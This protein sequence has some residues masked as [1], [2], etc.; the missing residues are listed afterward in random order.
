MYAV[1]AQTFGSLRMHK[2]LVFQVT[3]CVLGDVCLL[4]CQSST[5]FNKWVRKHEKFF[6]L[7]QY[8]VLREISF[9]AEFCNCIA[10]VGNSKHAGQFYY[11]LQS[12]CRLLWKR[13][14]I[15]WDTPVNTK[16][17]L[18]MWFISWLSRGSIDL[19]HSGNW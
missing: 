6:F 5:V 7:S 15:R 13:K 16:T 17:R 18:F 19:R 12:H 11:Q 1:D 2:N 9:I 10:N 14:L 3:K 8:Y 4:V